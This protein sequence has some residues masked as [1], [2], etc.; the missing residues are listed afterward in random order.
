MPPST[1]C[2]T[3]ALRECAKTTGGSREPAAMVLH[4]RELP[5]DLDRACLHEGLELR[6]AR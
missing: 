4:E 1:T 5:P 3:E 2:S 6:R